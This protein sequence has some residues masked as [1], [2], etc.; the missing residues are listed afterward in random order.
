MTLKPMMKKTIVM[1]LD[2]CRS[3]PATSG[4]GLA[5]IDLGVLGRLDFTDPDE[6]YV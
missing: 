2:P 1:T 4:V 6:S 3:V 5:S